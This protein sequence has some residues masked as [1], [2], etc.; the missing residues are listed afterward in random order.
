M[1]RQQHMHL[2][3]LTVS[4]L[5]NLSRASLRGREY[6]GCGKRSRGH[7]CIVTK[8]GERGK[9]EKKTLNVMERVECS[10]IK[11]AE[12]SSTISL[13]PPFSY[14]P[15]YPVCSQ[16]GSSSSSSSSLSSSSSSS[17]SPVPFDHRSPYAFTVNKESRPRHKRNNMDQSCC[18][19]VSFFFIS[20]LALTLLLI[21]LS[22]STKVMKEGMSQ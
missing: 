14:I 7:G 6:R 5:Q 1:D 3:V 12:F 9:W 13:P 18:V 22:Q 8:Y 2:S 15:K 4:R 20:L 10:T 17:S 11:T 21:Y 19:I 16:P